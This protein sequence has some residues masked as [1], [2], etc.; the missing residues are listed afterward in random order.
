MDVYMN[1]LNPKE[2]SEK[3]TYSQLYEPLNWIVSADYE[4]NEITKNIINVISVL[5]I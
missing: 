3:L 2:D 1:S 5:T 4:I